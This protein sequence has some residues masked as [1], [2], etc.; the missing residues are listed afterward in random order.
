[1]TESERRALRALIDEAKRAALPPICARCG[2]EFEPHPLG[3]AK[4]YCSDRCRRRHWHEA[5]ERGRAYNAEKKRRWH[6]R[7]KERAA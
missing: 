4:R 2:T 3:L 6:E 5:T 1:M 7:R